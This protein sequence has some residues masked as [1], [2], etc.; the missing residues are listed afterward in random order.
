[1]P[2][3]ATVMTSDIERLIAS[4]GGVSAAKVVTDAEGR[5]VEVHVLADT[6]RSPKQLVRDIQS[7]TMAAF[8]L[9]IDY[10]IVSVAQVE[11]GLQSGAVP[12]AATPPTPVRPSPR[13][14]C[15]SL[16]VHATRSTVDVVVTLDLGGKRFEG[17]AQ[18]PATERGR[19]YACASASLDAVH[20][21]LGS[22]GILQLLEVRML[23]IA[24]L[25]AIEAAVAFLEGEREILL[26]GSAFV[27]QRNGEDDSVVR[28]VLDALNRVITRADRD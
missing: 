25:D 3:N 18:G 7:S 4:I 20:V 13:L 12:T 17:H 16:A 23:H 27:R 11:L 1:M 28:A 24:G 15:E 19:L 21:Y 22:E 14:L 6:S 5:I 10:R 8:G 26:L 2:E 9:P